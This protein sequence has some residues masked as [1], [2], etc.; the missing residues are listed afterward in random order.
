MLKQG[1]GIELDLQGATGRALASAKPI[2][3]RFM[4]RDFTIWKVGGFILG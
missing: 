4:N 1:S 2:M 3:Q